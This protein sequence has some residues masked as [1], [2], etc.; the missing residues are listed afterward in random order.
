MRP[1]RGWRQD[2]DGPWTG[3]LRADLRS[4]RSLAGKQTRMRRVRI[5]ARPFMYPA[6]LRETQER[7]L[8]E[9]W[10]KSAPRRSGAAVA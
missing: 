7:K 2:R 5:A 3:W 1:P 6:M 10:A 9:L 8:D 4:R